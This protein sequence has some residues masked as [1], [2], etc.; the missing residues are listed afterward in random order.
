MHG[1]EILREAFSACLKAE[2]SLR[3]S[4]IGQ[5]SGRRM[6]LLISL[7]NLLKAAFV[8]YAQQSSQTTTSSPD[9]RHLA[10]ACLIEPQALELYSRLLAHKHAAEWHVEVTFAIFHNSTVVF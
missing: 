9:A 7:Q 4:V 10:A 3:S 2:S 5:R 6:K 1:E 8:H